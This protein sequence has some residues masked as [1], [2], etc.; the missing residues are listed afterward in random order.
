[1]ILFIV[2]YKF[3][4]MAGKIRDFVDKLTEQSLILQNATLKIGKVTDILD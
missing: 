4:S 3:S 2:S 1:M